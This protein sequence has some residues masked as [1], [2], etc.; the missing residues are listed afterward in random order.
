MRDQLLFVAGKLDPRMGGPELDQAA[1]LTV[2]RRSLY[3]RHAHEKQMELLK[4][5]DAAGVSECYQR[6]ES[7]VPQQAL[8]LVNSPLSD[9]MAKALAKELSAKSDPAK[10]TDA[11]FVRVIGRPPTAAEA[12]ECAAFLADAK[13]PADRRAALVLVLF[14]HHEFVT[15]R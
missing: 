15:V 11:A 6:R 1:G 2:Y 10:F 9:A 12:K 14:N 13:P 4:L 5:F 7:V 8:A 3:F